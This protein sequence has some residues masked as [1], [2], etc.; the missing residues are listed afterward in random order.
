MVFIYLYMFCMKLSGKTAIKI[1]DQERSALD[2]VRRFTQ[3]V[4][5]YSAGAKNDIDF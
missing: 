2:H 4:L 1:R 5:F 3:D